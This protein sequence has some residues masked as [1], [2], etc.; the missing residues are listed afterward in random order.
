ME[1]RTDY[2]AAKQE[3][4][5]EAGVRGRIGKKSVGHFDYVK[6]L[7]NGAQKICRVDVY[8]LKV[9]NMKRVWPEKLERTRAWLSVE[10]AAERVGEEGLKSL[11]L[12]Y[13][14]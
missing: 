13:K 7:K 8:P 4:F 9:F 6:H 11:I 14:N 1:G 10:V 12:R 5:E 2:N 3:A